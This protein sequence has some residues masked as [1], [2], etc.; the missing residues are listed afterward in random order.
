M[1]NTLKYDLELDFSKPPKVNGAI[2]IEWL[3]IRLTLILYI[4]IN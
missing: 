3:E 2:K 1:Y 4:H